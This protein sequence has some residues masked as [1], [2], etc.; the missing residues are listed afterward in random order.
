MV[1]I[2]PKKYLPSN[3]SREHVEKMGRF[4]VL[5]SM[6]AAT[7]YMYSHYPLVG[8][9]GFSKMVISGRDDF[10]YIYY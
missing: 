5:I 7:G 1:V 8:N 9:R 2:V 4:F 10:E 3:Y 6:F